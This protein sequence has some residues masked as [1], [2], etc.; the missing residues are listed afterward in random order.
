[1]KL[2]KHLLLFVFGV[3]LLPRIVLGQTATA[4]PRP[5]LSLEQCLDYALQNSP[6]IKQSQIDEQIGER[7]IKSSLSGW[8]PQVSAAFNASH[9]IKLQTQVIGGQL[10]TFGQNYNSNLQFQVNQTLFSR[11]QFFASKTADVVRGQLDQSLT[12]SKIATTVAVSKAYYDILLTYEQIKILD[13]NLSRLNKQYSDAKSRYESGIVDKT[14]Y[15]RASISLSN[16]K[17]DKKRVE[18]SIKAK[19]T[20]LKE[21]MGYPTEENLELDFDYKQMENEVEA[22]TAMALQLEN[23]IE[24]KLLRSQIT[25]SDLQVRYEKW[26]FIPEVSAYYN[27]NWNF[28][29]NQAGDLYRQSYPTSA[30]GLSFGIP[31]F[32]GGKRTQQIKLAELNQEKNQVEMDNLKKQI[33]TEYQSALADYKSSLF[34][35]Q[36]VQENMELAE[37]VYGIIKLQYDEGIK[38]YVDLIIAETELRTAQLN[39]YNALFKVLASKLDLQ[40]ALGNIEIN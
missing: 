7:Q 5:A 9:N 17:S 21:L 2:S 33:N 19:N 12:N 13:E 24:Y 36:T 11:D 18:T 39:H 14:D 35:W 22:D 28:F 30:V 27:H 1:M 4:L 16:L 15:Q 25:F 8:L 34:E 38:A 10:I 3:S 29:N 23:R 20:Y 6:I 26:A 37:E 32:Q 31:I 40:K